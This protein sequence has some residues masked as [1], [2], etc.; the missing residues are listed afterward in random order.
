MGARREEFKKMPHRRKKLYDGVKIVTKQSTTDTFA[1]AV[2]G[3]DCFATILTAGAE[4]FG[5]GLGHLSK[6]FDLVSPHF[7]L[8]QVHTVPLQ[9]CPIYGIHCTVIISASVRTTMRVYR[10]RPKVGSI[11]YPGNWRT[12]CTYTDILLPN[13]RSEVAYILSRPTGTFA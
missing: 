7:D 6:F 8:F 1:F 3:A 10:S 13:Y 5:D 12:Q 9:Y 11:A 4:F 2:A